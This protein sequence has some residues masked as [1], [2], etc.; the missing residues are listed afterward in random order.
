MLPGS[1]EPYDSAG[2]TK[3]T[4]PRKR[5]SRKKADPAPAPDATSD[6]TGDGVEPGSVDDE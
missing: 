1:W 4:A 2:E 5:T 6:A 3:K